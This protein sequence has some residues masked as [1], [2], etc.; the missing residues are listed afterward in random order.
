[1]NKFKFFSACKT[2]QELK[3]TFRELVKLHH[4]DK[5]ETSKP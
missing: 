5:P 2:I 1:M 3:L 4:P